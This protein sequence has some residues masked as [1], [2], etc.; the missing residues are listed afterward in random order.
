MLVAVNAGTDSATLDLSLA[1]LIKEGGRLVEEWSQE[2]IVVD[3]G[4]ARQIR[5]PPRKGI[6][7]AVHPRAK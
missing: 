1:P 4:I 5:I 3:D 6:V 7:W 2:E